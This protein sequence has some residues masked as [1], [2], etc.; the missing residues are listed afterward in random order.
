MTYRARFWIDDVFEATYRIVLLGFSRIVG[1]VDRY[2][3]DGVVNVLSAWTLT[4]GDELR[5]MQT[6]RAQD[7]V[8]SIAVG[9]GVLLLWVHWLTV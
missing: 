4:T 2:I 1:W 5:Q 9:L 6:G 8:Y 3:V 7:Y